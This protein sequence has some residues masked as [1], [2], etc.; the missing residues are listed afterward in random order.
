M[1]SDVMDRLANARPSHLDPGQ[2]LDPATRD[3]ELATAFASPRA[4]RPRRR[5]RFLTLAV[6][7]PL[8][9]TAT[10]AAV[11]I[12]ATAVP[13]PAHLGPGHPRLIAALT[14]DR[15]PAR[16][17]DVAAVLRGLAARAAAQPAPALGPVEY[18]KAVIWG[19]PI[20]DVPRGLDYRAHDLRIAQEWRG[21]R[22]AGFTIRRPDGQAPS[23]VP[24]PAQRAP[25]PPADWAWR[26]PATLPSG[27]AALQRRLLA[28]PGSAVER[29]SRLLGNPRSYPTVVRVALTLMETEP[30]PPDVRASML[31]L[32]ATAMARPSAQVSYLDLGAVTDRAGRQGVAIA[33]LS[34]PVSA[35][36]ALVVYVFDRHTGALV[37][38]ED[39]HCRALV[40]A[41]TAT[42]DCSPGD[43]VEYLQI[44]A[45]H[46]VPHLPWV[47]GPDVPAARP[48]QPPKHS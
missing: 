37:G 19:L 43:Y 4:V 20:G 23:G 3:R 24:F 10:A 11:A 48:P 17:P 5:W 1:N 8:A 6:G 42:R 14:Y 18:V 32:M 45:V 7:G 34:R 12:A 41:W 33:S 35:P 13:Q 29:L 26:N 2:L 39:A 25:T 15:S 9:A 36:G 28:P 31:R 38:Q 46:T 44:K 21:P 47:A 40:T 27:R 16:S 22:S 30:L